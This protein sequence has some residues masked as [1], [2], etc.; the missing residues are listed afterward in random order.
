MKKLL[1]LL[2]VAGAGYYFLWPKVKEQVA[3]SPEKSF[4]QDA[5]TRANAVLLGMQGKSPERLGLPEQYALSQWA[6]GKIVLDRDNMERYTNRFDQFRQSRDL[7]RTIRSYEITNVRYDD[8]GAEPAAVVEFTVDGRQYK[9]I[10][11]K[12]EPIAWRS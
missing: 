5:R 10:V 1:I 4:L 7:F 3:P 2:V 9:W 11:R 12:G 8:S 6:E